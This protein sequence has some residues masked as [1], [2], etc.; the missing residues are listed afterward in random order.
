MEYRISKEI[1]TDVA[2]VGGGTAGVFAAIAAARSGAKVFLIEKNSILG[3]TLTASNVNFPGL[4]FAWG[5]QIISGPCW[6]SIEK[7]AKL[8]GA[9]LPA[10]S[11]KP[12]NHW[13]EQILLNKFIYTA[14]LFEMCEEA[15]IELLCNSMIS[16]VV[17]SETSTKLIVCCKN[18]TICINA[19]TVIDATGDANL[20]EIAG[21]ALLKSEPQ[22]PAT[23]QNR[24]SG[25]DISSFSEDEIREKF[26]QDSFPHYINAEN[27]IHYL[28]IHKLDIHIPSSDAE[29]SSGRTKIEQCSY[30]L[31]LK[32]YSFLRSIKGLENL[33]IDFIADECGIRESNRILGETVINADDYINGY[34]YHDSVCYAFYPIDL[35]V[36]DGIKQKFHKE[37]IV[38]K[39][40]Y[41]ALIPK[42]SKRIL[43]AGRC[44]SSDTYA[45]SGIRVE[46]TCMATGQAAGCAAAIASKKNIFISD[47][48]Y[49]E[50][51]ESLKKLNAIVPK[52]TEN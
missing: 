43:C 17:E 15:K 33:E 49:S 37:N 41:S 35:H 46:A 40:P 39:I 2:V 19:K 8:G 7:T 20:C 3:G 23:P 31:L 27:I 38:S 1:D 6:E 42:G 12:K 47:V 52:K 11:F 24:L 28:H 13:D 16:A 29:S 26:K 10:I 4:F 14:V 30:S 5:K 45:N 44:I 25:Y 48:P 50:L 9:V 32:L 36:M 51:C 22:Q 18:S 34:F 21:Y